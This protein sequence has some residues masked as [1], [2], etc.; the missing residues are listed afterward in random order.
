MMMP[1]PRRQAVMQTTGKDTDNNEAATD[2]DAAMQST[3]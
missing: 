1:Q 3:W 2:V